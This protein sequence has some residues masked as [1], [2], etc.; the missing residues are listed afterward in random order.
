MGLICHAVCVTGP[1]FDCFVAD[2]WSVV[3]QLKQ[4]EHTVTR[5]LSDCRIDV[6]LISNQA[7]CATRLVFI[8]S[9]GVRFDRMASVRGAVNAV[10]V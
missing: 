3:R 5:F 8:F 4:W 1:H 7:L 2:L 10:V 6:A 9:R